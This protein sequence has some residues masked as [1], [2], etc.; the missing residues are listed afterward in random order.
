MGEHAGNGA[1]PAGTHVRIPLK[2]ATAKNLL[3]LNGE[4]QVA[5][6]QF[7][8][9]QQRLQDSLRSFFTEHDLPNGS[10]AIEVTEHPPYELVVLVGLDPQTSQETSAS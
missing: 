8:L 2:E 9:N 4:L 1:A 6:A 5:R 7:A 3:L 10:R